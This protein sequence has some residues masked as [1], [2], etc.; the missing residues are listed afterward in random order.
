M[1]VV[2]APKM[3]LKIYRKHFFLL[4][5][6]LSNAIKWAANKSVDGVR[7]EENNCSKIIDSQGKIVEKSCSTNGSTDSERRRKTCY[8][9]R[10][11][12][13]KTKKESKLCCITYWIPF[14]FA[15]NVKQWFCNKT[16]ENEREFVWFTFSLLRF[17]IFAPSLNVYESKFIYWSWFLR[18][19]FFLLFFQL[20]F[21]PSNPR[22]KGEANGGRMEEKHIFI[23]N[24]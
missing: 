3:T 22:K 17:F 20:F 4:N 15:S 9:I 8:V 23:I 21:S 1:D 10:G 14:S 16:T 12:E 18:K 11:K 19:T 13:E 5:F 2:R 6:A 7:V 24:R